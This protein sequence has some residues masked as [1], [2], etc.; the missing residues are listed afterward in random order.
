MNHRGR[1]NNR[2]NASSG[3]LR[4]L[5]LILL[6]LAWILPGLVGHDPWKPDEA[7]SFGLVN[8]I[9]KSGDWVVPTLAG[10][11]FMEKPPLY[12][13]TA[14]TCARLF[15]PPLPLHDAARLTSGLFMALTLLFAGL[16]GRELYGRGRGFLTALI[17]IGCLG[18]L[19][20]A[21]ELITDVALLTGFSV[22]FYGL[23][24][25]LRRPLWGGLLLGTGTGIGFLS[26]G[27]IAPG[28]IGVTAL[29]LPLMFRPWRSRNYGW[30]LAAALLAALP[31]LTIW[32]YALYQ[33]S[34]ELFAEWL[35]TNNLG[36]FLGFAHLGPKGG[37]GA[38][39]E[40][41]PW[42]TWPALP[43]ALWTLWRDK[44]A[45]L[46]RPEIQLPL[47]AFL[48]MVVILSIASD[49]REVYALPLL[50]P[51]SQL[52]AAGVATLRRGAAGAL[53][54][55]GV[56]GFTFFAGVF[57]FYWVAVEFGVPAG[58]AEHL[59]DLQ[60]GYTPSFNAWVF[61]LGLLYTLGWV[62]TIVRLKRSP[63]RPIIVWAAGMTLVWG[64]LAI[65][66]V[67]WV[68]AGKSYRSMV[69]SLRLA[70][71]AHYNCMASRNLGEPQ[72]AMLE[73]Y[74]NIITR[75]EE[76]V[77]KTQCNLL[78][79]QGWS[80]DNIPGPGPKWRQIWEGSRPGDKN[81]RYRLFQRIAPGYG[82]AMRQRPV[83]R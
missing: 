44:R 36:R 1:G 61:G 54:W 2:T 26:K 83:P 34:P 11:P 9:L 21:H 53:Y 65:L 13:I 58:L 18:I 60:P 45:G 10:E 33:R 52:A 14:A 40:I 55:F 48:A 79:I 15:S 8:H 71:P 57:W 67:S 22:A 66:F 43:L 29:L 41:L 63:E 56:M 42:F 5:L 51:L 6:F 76:V 73:Y 68:D 30:T 4:P 59:K 20:H 82:G 72:R 64:L 49:G 3:G 81:E 27:L 46:A 39:L 69:A 50:L 47:T 23:A 32:P 80:G 25:C 38:Y 12:Y 62:V 28:M 7:Y 78:L 16:T 19:T 37:P 17:L 77:G 24:L 35:W 31:W 74:A 70:L 75:R